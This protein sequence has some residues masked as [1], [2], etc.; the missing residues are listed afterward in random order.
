MPYVFEVEKKDQLFT[1]S[2]KMTSAWYQKI[3][4]RTINNICLTEYLMRPKT[5][6]SFIMVR[7]YKQNYNKRVRLFVTKSGNFS[8]KSFNSFTLYLID[9]GKEVIES[10]MQGFNSTIF[11]YGQTASGKTHTMMGPKVGKEDGLIPQ[12]LNKK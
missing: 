5:T 4:S 1:G 12:V 7:N 3:L 10:A 8:Y 11:A 9:V 2:Q 6:I